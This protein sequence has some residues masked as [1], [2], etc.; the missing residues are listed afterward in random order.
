MKDLLL[1]IF[2]KHVSKRDGFINGVLPT[3]ILKKIL[4][5][6]D[7]SRVSNRSGVLNMRGV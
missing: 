6:L 4:E 7:Y 5:K 1:R 2:G 3:E